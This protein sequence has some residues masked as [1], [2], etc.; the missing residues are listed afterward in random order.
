VPAR[1]FVMEGFGKW[2]CFLELGLWLRPEA[3][4]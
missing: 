3:D 2:R 1:L 4:L